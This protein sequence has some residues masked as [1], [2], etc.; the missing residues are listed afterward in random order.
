MPR[1]I[2]SIECKLCNKKFS[3]VGLATHLKTKHNMSNDAYVQQYGEFRKNVLKKVM[4]DTDPCLICN[5]GITYNPVGL[6][7]HLKKHHNMNKVEYV[8][9]HILHNNIPT[10]KCG[11]GEPVPIKYYKPYI[12]TEYVSGHNSRG[13][14]NSRYGVN[15]STTTRRKMQLK[16]VSRME[17]YKLAGILAPMHFPEAIATRGKLQTDK[18]IAR[19][20]R[21]YNVKILERN[22]ENDVIEWVVQCNACN[23]VFTQ[24]HAAYFTC[25]ICNVRNRSMKEQ[26]L[27]DV[28]NSLGVQFIANDRKILKNNR[29]L[30]FYFPKHNLAIEFDG[31]YWHSEL[32]GKDRTYHLQKTLEC[33][34]KG[35]QLLHIFEDEWEHHREIVIGKIKSLL[36]KDDRISVYARMTELREISSKESRDFLDTHHL[37][38]ADTAKYRVG[39][40]YN[41]ILVSVMTFS[42]PNASKGNIRNVSSGTYELSRYCTHAKYRCIGG[43]SKLLKY[44]IKTYQ[45]TSIVS[46]A[47]RR[48]STVTRNVYE[49][50]GFTLSHES[51]PNYWYFSGKTGLKRY[52]RFNF[53]KKKTIQ[54]GGNPSK[55][56][57][58]NMIELGYNRIWDCGHLKYE[59]DL[60]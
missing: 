43:A 41:N 1:T 21:E 12:V 10:C 52:H 39:L 44:F 35:I 6:T 37:Q 5:D 17:Q 26:E 36:K 59:I 25:W 16:A 18:L 8:T 14:N 38:G 30:D 32:Q 42:K 40:F 55:T 47:D 57:W 56:E 53:T 27:I 11:C 46:Y 60:R 22:K 51:S 50:L 54:L 49:T 45:P 29:E 33:E 4:D 15:V 28:F 7:W 31:I 13:V 24:Y 23:N 3:S 19:C 20:E 2:Q 48:Y 58:E 9:K 34:A